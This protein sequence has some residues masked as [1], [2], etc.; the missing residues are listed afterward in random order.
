MTSLLEKF[1][2]GDKVTGPKSPVG[3][4]YSNAPQ[5]RILGTQRNT[6]TCGH[7]QLGRR[8]KA[9]IQVLSREYWQSMNGLRPRAPGEDGCR[10]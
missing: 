9:V 6:C 3:Q 10:A 2:V 8:V 5:V 1:R 4:V 7:G